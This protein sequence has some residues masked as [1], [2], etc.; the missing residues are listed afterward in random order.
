MT[1]DLDQMLLLTSRLVKMKTVT[2][3]SYT[4]H[5][6][7]IAV[8]LKD[9]V[10]F[11][12]VQMVPGKRNPSII[13]TSEEHPD[14]IK[15]LIDGHTDTV[16]AKDP[17]AWLDNDPWSGAITGEYPNQ[18]VHGRG[19][20][21]VKGL[22]AGTFGAVQRVGIGNLRGLALVLASGEESGMDG[23]AETLKYWPESTIPPPHAVLVLEPT[24]G[25]GIYAHKG[26]YMIQVKVTGEASHSAYP[27]Q[28]LNAVYWGNEFFNRTRHI[29]KL[30]SRVRHQDF[31][32]PGD[33]SYP[34]FEATLASGGEATNVMPSH[35]EITFNFR[36]LPGNIIGQPPLDWLNQQ[37]ETIRGQ[38]I[39]DVKKTTGKDLKIDIRIPVSA[40]PFFSSK[41]SEL[42]SAVL[43]AY[44]SGATTVSYATHASRYMEWWPRFHQNSSLENN[45]QIVVAGP[46]DINKNNAHKPNEHISGNE[47]A[48]TADGME[49]I[50]RTLCYL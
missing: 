9:D 29:N 5:V 38:L 4:E 1:H 48:K 28:G 42:M 49:K 13:A 26:N 47:L 17:Q 24:D 6:R 12:Y 25:Q 37:L 2:D 31:N 11:P 46:G 18:I 14:E 7:D 23:I 35:Y 8:I 16:P 19:A 3:D 50:I 32:G 36:P 33:L 27:S 30:L 40:S 44:S 41:D 21:D 34:T 43:R 15:L 10:G 22:I 39:Q 45:P 20:A